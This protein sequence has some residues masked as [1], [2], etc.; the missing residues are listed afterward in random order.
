MKFERKKM[1][2]WY[3]VRQLAAT[4]VKSLISSMFGNYADKREIQAV[5]NHEPFYDYSSAEG[6]DREELWIDY[7]ADLADGFDSTYTMAHLL[8]QDGITLANTKLPRGKVLLMG[9]DQVYPTPEKVEYQN[10]LQGPYNAA[11]PWDDEDT[12]RPHLFALPGNHDWYDGLNNFIKLFCQGRALGNW[13]TQQKRSYFAL[14]LP[15]RFWIWGIDV[16]LKADIDLPQQEYF[17]QMAQYMEPSDQVILCT[18]EPAWVYHSLRKEDTSYDR[19]RFFSDKFIRGKDFRLAAVL[20]GDLHHYARYAPQDDEAEGQLITAGGGGAFLHPTHNLKDELEGLDGNHS[21][22]KSSFPSKKTSRNIALRN[23]LFPFINRSFALFLGIFH[24]L[25]A[26]LLQSDTKY[27]AA[28][29]YMKQLSEISFTIGNIPI[30]FEKTCAVLLHAPS[31]VVFNLILL[32]GLTLFA[33]TLSGKGK[34]NYIAGFL[35]G[36]FHLTCFYLL[37]WFFSRINLYCDYLGWSVN[38]GKQILLFMG[39]MLIAGSLSGAF[40]FGLYL[41]FSN[42]WFGMHDNEAFGSL[43]W[44]DHKNFLRLHISKEGLTI[45]PVAVEKVVK[46]WQQSGPDDKPRFTGSPIKSSL[47]ENPIHIKTR[48]HE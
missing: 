20:T 5:L 11:Y 38:S 7:I 4:G 30:V 33:D 12:D 13:H 46:D 43:Q 9:G 36:V 24:L 41:L 45:Y 27:E 17:D 35:H 23:L 39:E 25:I 2:N 32:L 44:A 22:L 6:K 15:H 3:D 42:R 1:V 26:W 29:S 14:K 16:Q 34:W 40:L 31:A 28:G 21:Q 18:A 48:K 47:I 19:L 10:R 8:G 37:I